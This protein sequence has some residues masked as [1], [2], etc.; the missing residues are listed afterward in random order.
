MGKSCVC[1]TQDFCLI[2]L[3]DTVLLCPAC[4]TPPAQTIYPASPLEF[5]V[6][7]FLKIRRIG[8]IQNGYILGCP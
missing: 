5:V 6:S 7:Y 8:K 2:L 3:A 1:K 4:A